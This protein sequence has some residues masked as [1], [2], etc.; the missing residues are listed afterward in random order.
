MNENYVCDCYKKNH[1]ESYFSNHSSLKHN[2]ACK[3]FINEKEKFTNKDLK[4]I[5]IKIINQ[6]IFAFFSILGTI[7]YILIII[8]SFK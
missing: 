3:N 5:R 2:K 4:I 1:N 8:Y 6:I 7:I